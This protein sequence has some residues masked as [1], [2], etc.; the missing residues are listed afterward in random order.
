MGCLGPQQLKEYEALSNT[1]NNSA[2]K[3]IKATRPLDA[4][5]HNHHEEPTNPGSPKLKVIHILLNLQ[6]IRRFQIIFLLLLQRKSTASVLN[7]TFEHEDDDEQQS[8][9][10][11]IQSSPN[12]NNELVNESI[13]AA[14]PVNETEEEEEDKFQTPAPS[15]SPADVELDV[16]ALKEGR[17]DELLETI[18][19]LVQAV[20]LVGIDLII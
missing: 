11:A 12:V 19:A 7:T 4:N 6:I 20:S 13:G 14:C 9:A 17:V 5:Q 2:R 15:S 8:E 1:A 3:S 10:A 16:N 18:L